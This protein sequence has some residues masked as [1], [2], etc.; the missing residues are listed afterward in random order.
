MNNQLHS[1]KLNSLRF[2]AM[3][4][5]LILSACSS[6]IEQ[7]YKQLNA[8]VMKIHDDAMSEMHKLV[9]LKKKIM[10]DSTLSS[11]DEGVQAI[12]MLEKADKHMM[13]W[14]R[15]FKK[16]EQIDEA[17]IAY[18][19]QQLESVQLMAEEIYGAIEYAEKVKK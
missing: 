10:S 2:V 14:M 3:I 7:E 9:S 5:L 4:A 12:K 8:E 1:M 16:P 17:A 11:T 13:A 18:L 19:E 15:N 6:P